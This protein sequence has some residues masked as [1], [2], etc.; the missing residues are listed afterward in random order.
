MVS[1]DL[2]FTLDASLPF[3]FDVDASGSTNDKIVLS[4]R[5]PKIFTTV[6]SLDGAT[7]RINPFGPVSDGDTFDLIDADKIQGSP[8]IVSTDPSQN[9]LF[10]GETGEVTLSGQAS[11]LLKASDANQDLEFNQGDLVKVLGANTYLTGAPA[12]WG[13]G[14]WDAALTPAGPGRQGGP[15]P[16]DGR[17]D[18][19]D[20]VNRQLPFC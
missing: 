8:L 1:A 14:D 12:T 2:L 6:V 7:L 11:P 13:T 20:I 5:D 17:F 19:N 16:G 4:N 3:E 10:N 9:W 15:N 18:P